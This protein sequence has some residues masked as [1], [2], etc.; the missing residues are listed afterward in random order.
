MAY[1]ITTED[2]E[3]PDRD[4]DEEGDDPLLTSGTSEAA[5][6]N[7]KM[8]SRVKAAPA[9]SAVA[10]AFV[11]ELMLQQWLHTGVRC[12]EEM[13]INDYPQQARWKVTNKEALANLNDLTGCTVTTKGQYYPTGRNPPVGQRRLYLW[14]EGNSLEEVKSC[15]IEVKR[16]LDEA[17]STARPEEKPQ[18]GRYTV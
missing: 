5:Q 3:K 13:E 9:G 16:I 1:G 7:Q 12:S 2:D 15:K 4:E 14:I 6:E 17:M 10:N 11:Q 18:Y 8:L